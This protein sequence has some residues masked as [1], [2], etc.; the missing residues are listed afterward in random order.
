MTTVDGETAGP[1]TGGAPRTGG[2]HT[3]DLG[4]DWSIWRLCAVRGDRVA[5]APRFGGRMPPSRH[6]K[7]LATVA[8]YVQRYALKN[9]SIGFFGPVGWAYWTDDVDAVTIEPGPDLLA[10]RTVYFE[11]WAV[12]ALALALTADPTIQASLPLRCSPEN[13]VDGSC[14][15]TPSGGRIELTAAETL[16]I[17]ACDGTLTVDQIV[18]RVRGRPAGGVEPLPSRTALVAAWTRCAIGS[19]CYANRTYRTAHAPRSQRPT[20]LIRPTFTQRPVARP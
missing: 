14:L 12:D 9:D 16:V 5:E 17:K 20:G 13:F 2:G 19:F 11:V 6:R 18:E 8:N 15:V 10:G 3:V 7:N 1:D 4:D